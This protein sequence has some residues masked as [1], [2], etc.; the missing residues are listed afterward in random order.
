MNAELIETV[1]ALPLPERVELV[2]LL[3]ESIV[4]EGYE[5]LL[6]N[7]QAE[8]LDRRVQ[9]HQQNPADVVSWEQIKADAA[10]RY[11]PS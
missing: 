9:A 11:E 3:W 10:A 2:D 1:K 6:T 7:A 5:P 4:A 8:E